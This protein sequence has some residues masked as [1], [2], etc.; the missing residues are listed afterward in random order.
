MY[1][2]IQADLRRDAADETLPEHVR[3]MAETLQSALDLYLKNRFPDARR[4]T[5]PTGT[6]L[7]KPKPS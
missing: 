2:E 1:D 4:R 5:D 3:R 6:P 7:V